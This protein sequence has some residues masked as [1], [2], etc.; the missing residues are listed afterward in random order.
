MANVVTEYTKINGTRYLVHKI[1]IAG[2]G[3]G[4]ETAKVV[5]DV[6]ALGCTEVRLLKVFSC[7]GGFTGLLSWDAT[8]DVPIINLP[9]GEMHISA[10]DYGGLS[11]N[12]GA[13]KTGDIVLKTTGLGA[14]EFGT[15]IFE[16]EKNA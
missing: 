1:V 6:S 12:A 2:D 5:I 7:L 9:D 4:D 13:G 15:I 3:S 11:N 8:T 14:N 16:L 10:T